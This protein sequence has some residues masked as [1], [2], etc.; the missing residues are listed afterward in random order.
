MNRKS[1]TVLIGSI[2]IGIVIML[3]VYMGLIV[4]GVIDTR[5]STLVV[6]IESAQKEFD[7]K[8]LTCEKYTIKKGALKKGHNHAHDRKDQDRE[9]GHNYHENPSKA[10]VDGKTHNDCEN[11]LERYSNGNSQT[12]LI[13]VLDVGDVG[14]QSCNERGGGK[15]IHVRKREFLHLIK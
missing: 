2:V 12:H 11:K 5:P 10:C 4:T 1:S 6:A 8:E 15:F 14:R 13:G 3:A 7:G 9:H